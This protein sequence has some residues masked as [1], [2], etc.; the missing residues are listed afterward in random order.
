[1][2]GPIYSHHKSKLAGG[3]TLMCIVCRPFE[4]VSGESFKFFGDPKTVT[5][6]HLEGWSLVR[7]KYREKTVHDRNLWPYI[8][9]V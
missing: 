7:G 4:L 2:A 8:R 9:G 5:S 3:A 6:G 1:M